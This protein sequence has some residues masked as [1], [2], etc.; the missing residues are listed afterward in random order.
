MGKKCI[1][2]LIAV[3]NELLRCGLA[4]TLE[5]CGEFRVIG[6][7]SRQGE[8]PMHR[9][10]DEVVAIVGSGVAL[11]HELADDCPRRR[12]IALLE[13][14]D[15]ETALLE[16]VQAG[17][18]GVL[19]TDCSADELQMAVRAVDSGVTYYDQ[20]SWWRILPAL[21]QSNVPPQAPSNARASSEELKRLT[22]RE[23]EV[24]SLVAEGWT[25]KDIAEELEVSTRT[26][27]AHRSNL[28][29]KLGTR[30]V[31]ELTRIAIRAGLS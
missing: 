18:L 27:E 29:A 28:S 25:S 30:S 13:D 31:A 23:R 26:V 4:A 5:S 19:Y 7:V 24:L 15:D 6:A 22:P 3:Q 21:P 2:V 1:E 16:A 17:A 10:Y 11:S 20:A 12:M 9:Q 14:R 8:L